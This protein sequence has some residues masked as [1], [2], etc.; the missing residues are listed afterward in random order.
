[1]SSYDLFIKR[2]I[3]T[4]MLTLSLIVF[5]V[6]GYQR[7]GVD[8]FPKMDFPVVTVSAILEG[9]SPEVIE[10]DVTDVLEEHLNTIAGVRELSSKSYQGAS[11]IRVEFELGRDI[12]I[13]AQDVRDKVARARYQLPQD[14]EPPVVDK[15]D[16]GNEPVLWIPVNSDRPL[17]EASEYVR[18]SMKPRLETIQ[19]VASVVLFGERE[20][21]IRIWLDGEAM[22]ARG[23]A[24]T[25]ILDAVRRE[26]V[27]LPGGE[28]ESHRV[29]Y[30]VK[31][32][33]EFRSVDE[34][35][36]LIVAFIDGAPVR[37][38]D[39]AR[40]EDGAADP[41]TIADFD[42][43]PTVGLGMRKQSGA[44][45]VAVV[46][47]TYQR[48]NELRPLLPAGFSFKEREAAADFS[49]S[50]R[51]SV[52]ETQ[53]ALVFGAV[54]AVLTVFV[55]LRR[56]R[57]TLI[58]AAAIPISLI[59]TFGIM[60]IFGFTLNTMTLL[61][62]ALAVGVVIDDAIVVLE[63]IERHRELGEA[64]YEAASKG[65]REIAFAATA[66]TVSIAVVFMPV[67]FV[68]GI[69]GSFLSEFGVT[70][71]ASVMISLIVALTL[72]PMLAARMP[73]PKERAHGSIYHRLERG[74]RWLESHYQRVIDW[75]LLHRMTTLGIAL[76]SFVMALF[77]GRSL[78]T[79]F[80]PP[81]DN[82]MFFVRFTTPP[83]TNLDTTYEYLQRN[84]RWVLGLPEVVGMFAGAGVGDRRQGGS[85]NEGIMFVI[86]KSKKDRDRT[87]Q[88]LVPLAR[89]ALGSI[90]GQH[91]RVFDLSNMMG[92]P[93]GGD[94]SFEIRGNVELAELDEVSDRFMLELQK[95]GGFVDL[96]KSLKLGLPEVRVLPDREKAAALGVD[97]RSLAM[98]IQAMI[99]GL[100][101]ATFKEGGERF[102]IRVRLEEDA[103]ND[104]ASIQRL[105]VRTRDGGVVELRNLV[106][107]QTGAAPSAIT[108]LDRQ[109]SVTVSGNLAGK[110]LGTAVA[111]AREIAAGILPEGVTL[112][113]SGQAQQFQ[114][115]VEQFGVALLL[116]V[117]VIYMVLAAQFESLSHPLTVMLAVPLALVGA[118]GGLFVR[119]MSINLFS[120][121]GMILLM[122]LV[123]KNSILLIDYANQLRAEGMDK[124]EAMRRAA[125]IR[126]RPVLMTAISMVFGVLP[127]AI[128]VGPGAETR[129]PMA[130]AS[131]AGMLSSTVLTLVVVP[132]FYVVLDDAILGV[133]RRLR[134]LLRRGEPQPA[135][136]QSAFAA[137]SPDPAA[138]TRFPV[139]TVR[140]G[141]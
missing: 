140:V 24:A 19:G 118:F 104:P 35:T 80:F 17:V 132:V 27:E 116:A 47:E 48:L 95:R 120:L 5:G 16:F 100:D 23:L 11:I 115:G 109:R 22:R 21:A 112:G 101:I 126:M 65:T 86:L 37:L 67:I 42:A 78:G 9:A 93:T 8:Q 106:Q 18:R 96:D 98:T 61:A 82:G 7:L 76:G 51:E 97:A 41:R 81:S 137:A 62:L 91:V 136:A 70:V 77:F 71:A 122:G 46:D 68:E 20:R 72:T 40:V 14:V 28:V 108:R 58:V 138:E 64:P 56:T 94:F 125:P 92:N 55:F 25:D 69:V 105:Y 10:Q 44:N 123:T 31:T 26:H 110:K 102:D 139:S 83:G 63:N 66:S 114:E 127:A 129:G 53:F 73:A 33:A 107:V 4:L 84:E 30:T 130:V 135:A 111:E 39:V 29:E 36:R 121:I 3:M 34:L 74:F 57:P 32:D 88:E 54:L 45:T 79:E 133:R 128:G 124:V 12:D 60:W 13:A 52:A 134:R 59:G 15:E 141:E 49:K 90:P 1:M 6:L 89:E 38:G 113:L 87:T 117:L 43:V 103:R 85:S 50:I 131:G 99:G 2:P 75:A 119:G